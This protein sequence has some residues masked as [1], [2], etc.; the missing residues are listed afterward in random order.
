M[1]GFFQ[2]VKEAW[3]SDVSGTLLFIVVRKLSILK[4]RLIEWKKAQGN[5]PMKL[6]EASLKLETLQS[7]LVSDPRDLLIHEQERMARFELDQFFRAEESMYKQRA[8]EL[9]GNLG[10][11]NTKYFY[12]LM[13]KRQSQAYIS[14][15]T[16]ADNNVYID[17]TSIAVV[18]VS[19]F[20]NI[21]GPAVQSQYPDLSHISPL[22]PNKAPEDYVWSVEGS[23]SKDPPKVSENWIS[24]T[25]LLTPIIATYTRSQCKSLHL[26]V[27]LE[28]AAG[29]LHPV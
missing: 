21:L 19:H 8:R 1:P 5:I 13:K 15:I 24:A 23:A 20:Q 7:L 28:E 18:F 11:S 27:D 12:R 14:Q 26:E 2:I 10:D 29:R 22:G 17:S 4:K 6:S 3:D 25:L 16:D 9:A